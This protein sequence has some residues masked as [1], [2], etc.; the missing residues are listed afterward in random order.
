MKT[1]LLL[2]STQ[3]PLQSTWEHWN[4]NLYVRRQ[5]ISCF[6]CQ[7]PEQYYQ[8]SAIC[9]LM[10]FLCWAIRMLSE[11]I[12]TDVWSFE[13]RLLVSCCDA[14]NQP[15]HDCLHCTKYYIEK[16]D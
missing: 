6:N 5:Q 4:S 8:R 3:T 16:L 7:A 1:L 13:S 10:V 2:F 9:K 15:G 11:W 12:T 14:G